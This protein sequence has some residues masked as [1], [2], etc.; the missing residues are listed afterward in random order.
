MNRAQVIVLL[1]SFAMMYGGCSKPPHIHAGGRYEALG[2]LVHEVRLADTISPAF[3]QSLRLDAITGSTFRY[4]SGE[5]ASYFTYVAD[6]DDVLKAITRLAFPVRDRT[7]DV[8]YHEVDSEEWNALRRTVGP[9]EI[10]GAAFFW[11]VDP[12]QFNIYESVKNEHHLLLV[13]RDSRRI[14]HR[15]HS[16]G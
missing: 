10:S 16:K 3:T 6:P 5:Q 7:A 2:P 9:Y 11:D 4:P 8:N 1:F 14:L 15:I 13:E 12:A